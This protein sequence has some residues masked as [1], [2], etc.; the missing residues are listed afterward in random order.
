LRAQG[1]VA[2]VLEVPARTH[3]D[4]LDDLADGDAT[5]FRSAHA[6]LSNS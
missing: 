4:V 6:L 3:F 5:L 1:C 2:E